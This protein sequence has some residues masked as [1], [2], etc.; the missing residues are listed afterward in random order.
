MRALA[1]RDL[2]DP[3]AR[4]RRLTP[5][6]PRPAT[7][8]PC[9]PGSL[10]RSSLE[11]AGGAVGHHGD[12]R[13]THTPA[14]EIQGASWA[15]CRRATRRMKG[16]QT[17]DAA[18]GLF[19]TE[20]VRRRTHGPAR[21]G[22]QRLFEQLPPSNLRA[23]VDDAAATMTPLLDMMGEGHRARR[24]PASSRRCR[25][26]RSVPGLSNLSRA[27][28][29]AAVGMAALRG[30]RESDP[31]RLRLSLTHMRRALDATEQDR[32]PVP[33]PVPHRPGSRPLP[34]LQTCPAP[35]PSL[36]RR[37]PAGGGPGAP[38]VPGTRCG[39]R[40][41]NELLAGEHAQGCWARADG[42]L[43]AVEE[44]RGHVVAGVRR[45]G[46][47]GRHG[48]GAAGGGRRRRDRPPLPRGE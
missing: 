2:P 42:H 20:R 43:L 22:A 9:R 23:I 4:L 3:D 19:S 25:R 46:P 13:R 30:G 8:R 6:P 41:T 36:R 32:E 37:K 27:M 18:L 33:G 48:L 7:T 5:W 31:G 10:L 45:A 29:H 34:A 38:A 24:R 17:L 39:R 26:R 15:G 11:R 47:G 44:L 35:S 40:S 1:E 12:A 28:A 16:L 21:S 14:Q